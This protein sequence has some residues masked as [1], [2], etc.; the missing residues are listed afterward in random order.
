[1]K[2]REAPGYNPG[3]LEGPFDLDLAAQPPGSGRFVFSASNTRF[4]S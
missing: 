2:F 1:M 3:Q 4:S